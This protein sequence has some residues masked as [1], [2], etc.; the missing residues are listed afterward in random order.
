MRNGLDKS[1]FVGRWCGNLRQELALGC[2]LSRHRTDS[3]QTVAAQKKSCG[4]SKGYLSSYSHLLCS[5]SIATCSRMLL[6]VAFFR[7]QTFV[8]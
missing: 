3:T 4:P 2:G 1:W 7:Q 6:Q 8:D 5:D